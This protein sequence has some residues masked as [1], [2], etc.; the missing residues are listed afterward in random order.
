MKIAL[1]GATGFVG[2]AVLEEATSRGHDVK[3]IVRD[4]AKVPTASRVTAI[5]ADVNDVKELEKVIAGSDVVISAFNGGWGDADIYNKHLKG[6]RAIAKAA[7]SAGI[8]LITVGGAGSLYAPDGTQF[9]DGD[10]FPADWKAGATAAR[11]ALNELKAGSWQGWTFVS[12][13]FELA[14]GERTGKYRTGL[15]NPVFNDQGQSKISAS[16]LAVALVDEAEKPKHKGQ[17]FTVAY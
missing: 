6:S 11:D 1:I 12:P 5:K 13:P 15:E 7:E 4:T 2:S 17:R 3:A 9:V 8:R 10:A 14:P 16:D